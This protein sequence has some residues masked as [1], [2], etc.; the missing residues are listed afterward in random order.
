MSV[1]MLMNTIWGRKVGRYLQT[2]KKK[3]K[4]G[5]QDP[6]T[7][8]KLVKGDMVYV[9][10]GRNTGE[11]GKIIKVLRKTTQVIIEGVNLRK[12]IVRGPLGSGIPPKLMLRPCAIHYSNIALL[13]PATNKP[14]KFNIKWLE[15]GKKVRVAKGS[16]TII[17]KP[18]PFAGRKPRT[19]IIGPKDTLPVDVFEVTF[20]DYDK[21]LPFLYSRK[22]KDYVAKL[23]GSK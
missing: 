14:C 23:A 12:R 13:D 15:N 7:K 6:M 8:T 17:P 2:P 20:E 16:G 10:Q 1:N 3:F 4:P 9:I 5:Q 22:Y 11:S 21:F 19:T 18:D